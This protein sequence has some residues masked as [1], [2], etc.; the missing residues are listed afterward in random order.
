M[1]ALL[2]L[3]DESFWDSTSVLGDGFDD[4]SAGAVGN[5][6]TKRRGGFGSRVEY[7]LYLCVCEDGQQEQ[8]D[9]GVDVHRRRQGV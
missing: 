9:K 4:G 6:Q 1:G 3:Q 5:E 2:G 7:S 8:H